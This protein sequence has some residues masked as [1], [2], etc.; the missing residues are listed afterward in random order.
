VVAVRGVLDAGAVDALHAAVLR[1]GAGGTRPVL[2]DLAGVTL[3]TSAGARLLHEFA[4]YPARPRLRAPE[5]SP[6]A[7]VLRITGLATEP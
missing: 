1:A 7:R 6:V 2:L 5:D 4:R 3:L